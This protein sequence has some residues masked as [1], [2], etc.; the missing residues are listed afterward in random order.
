MNV[1]VYGIFDFG[2]GASLQRQPARNVLID[3]LPGERPEMLKDHR[4]IGARLEQM[5]S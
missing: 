4:D 5:A 1:V 3:R 2:L